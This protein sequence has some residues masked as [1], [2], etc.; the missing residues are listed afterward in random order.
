LGLFGKIAGFWEALGS[1][2]KIAG[3]LETL[4]SFGKNAAFVSGFSVCANCTH[5]T[6]RGRGI[7]D[8]HPAA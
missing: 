7:F 3:F 8:S 5:G 4:G 1:F 2:G 6:E